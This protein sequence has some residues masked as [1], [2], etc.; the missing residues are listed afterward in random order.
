ML[1]P[2]TLSFKLAIVAKSTFQT[3]RSKKNVE[4]SN[5]KLEVSKKL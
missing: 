1:E 2:R 5:K 3:F 4:K